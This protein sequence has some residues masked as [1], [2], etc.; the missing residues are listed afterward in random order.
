MAVNKLISYIRLPFT[1]DLISDKKTGMVR[2]T[3]R[4][5]PLYA[6]IKSVLL[7]RVGE[8][9][10]QANQPLPSEWELASQLDVSQGTVRKALG[11]L[12]AQGVL[13]RRQGLGTFVAE[14][15]SDWG[16]G[17]L[18]TPGIFDESPDTLGLE[19]LGCSRVNAAEEVANALGLRRGASL[20]RVRQLWRLGGL[21]AALDDAFLSA[22]VYGSL[23][24]R[25]VR[26]CGG[27]VYVALQR[28]FGVR[29]RVQCEQ[30]R[31]VL[32]EREDASMLGVSPDV[33]ALSL[34]RLSASVEGAPV[35]W[36]QRICL[37]STLAYTVCAG[38]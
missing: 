28:R 22:E 20:V 32:L 35:E 36:R 4:R 15:A 8:G 9:E 33:P 10:W 5:L 30:M 23:D 37:T 26:Q 25:T 12:V 24:A 3:L 11:E 2:N 16:G 13:Y 14:V 19:F 27:S 21:A 6:Q 34:L 18:V 1:L 7:R 17:S 29:P 38:R 31:G